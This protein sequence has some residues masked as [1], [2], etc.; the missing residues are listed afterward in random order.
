[1]MCLLGTM[2]PPRLRLDVGL[3]SRARRPWHPGSQDMTRGAPPPWPPRSLAARTPCCAGV[4]PDESSVCRVFIFKACHG[5][6][7]VPAIRLLKKSPYKLCTGLSICTSE[8]W[9]PSEKQTLTKMTG[10]APPPSGGE[11]GGGAAVAAHAGGAKVR[12]RGEL[13]L[14]VVAIAAVSALFTVLGA[15]NMRVSV[16]FGDRATPRLSPPIIAAA[17]AS[18]SL[19]PSASHADAGPV[20]SPSSL[21]PAPAPS[22]DSSRSPA[23]A[24]GTDSQKG[25]RRERREKRSQGG[26]CA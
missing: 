20:L 8:N 22:T 19:E 4:G 6:R 17:A 21:S 14:Q 5:N 3:L 15:G 25:R 23:D 2:A 10:D 11:G 9:I 7:L 26:A 12:G 18:R 13:L 1:V 16:H 24:A